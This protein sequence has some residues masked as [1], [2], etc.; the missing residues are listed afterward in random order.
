[1]ADPFDKILSDFQSS[2]FDHFTQQSIRWWRN[3]IRDLYGS[4]GAPVPPYKMPSKWLQAYRER[5]GKGRRGAASGKMYLFR[6]EPTTK[7][8]LQ[9][10]D[11]LPLVIA[12]EKKSGGFMGLNLHYLSKKRRGE[13]L[14]YMGNQLKNA[15]DDDVEQDFKG[16]KLRNIRTAFRKYK[17]LKSKAPVFKLAYPCIRRYKFTGLKSNLIEIPVTDWELA[18]YLPSDYFFKG[19][20]VDYIQRDSIDKKRKKFG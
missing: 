9:Y 6:Y 17:V 10:W 15:T 11:T 5:Y 1:M 4:E 19:E 3:T 13:L 8:N 7:E 16:E 14:N 20:S 12:L 18:A 2:R